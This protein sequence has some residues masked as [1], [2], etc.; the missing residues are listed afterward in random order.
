MISDTIRDVGFELVILLLVHTDK[1]TFISL[2]SNKPSDLVESEAKPFIVFV[3][4]N[5]VEPGPGNSNCV[6][7]RA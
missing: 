5:I 7:L 3:V 2:A 4:L 6:V 1:L